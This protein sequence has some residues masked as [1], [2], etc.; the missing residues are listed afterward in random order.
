MA[1]NSIGIYQAR[2]QRKS[3]NMQL[4]SYSESASTARQP[5]FSLKHPIPATRIDVECR[6]GM[7]N[8]C[9][10]AGELYAKV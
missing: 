2:G 3:P 8:E 9:N 4:L 1:E 6:C 10:L 7:T 5:T